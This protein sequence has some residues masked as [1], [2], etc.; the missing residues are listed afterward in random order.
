MAQKPSVLVRSCVLA[1]IAAFG[2]AGC[3]HAP[4]LMSPTLAVGVSSLSA[5]GVGGQKAQLCHVTGNGHFTSIEV[6]VAAEPTH[7]AH[8]DAAPG[9]AVPGQAGTVFGSDCV[10]SAEPQ[11]PGPAPG[12]A[13]ALVCG[14]PP[15]AVNPGSTSPPGPTLDTTGGAQIIQYQVTAVPAPAWAMIS[16][17]IYLDGAL[18]V[19]L[20]D[21]WLDSS[22]VYTQY[23][24][25]VNMNT[26]SAVY[27]VR[28][29]LDNSQCSLFWNLN[30]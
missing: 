8:G 29:W 18:F 24:H 7:R 19:T 1:A 21:R 23:N 30:P 3:G 20:P 15:N 17:A 13:Q 16:S 5:V 2:A 28:F 25:Q 22:G 12:P 6:S 10:P 4:G 14:A 27:E 11:A 9:E 26:T